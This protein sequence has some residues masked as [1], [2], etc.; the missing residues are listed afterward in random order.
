MGSTHKKI[1]VRVSCI[2]TVASPDEQIEELVGPIV[3]STQLV[4]F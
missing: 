2:L 1:G 3:G 4:P